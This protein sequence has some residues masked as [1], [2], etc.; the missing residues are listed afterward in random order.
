MRRRRISILILLFV[1]LLSAWGNVI[2]AAFCPRYLAQNCFAHK[3]KR[4]K[5]AEHE[6]CTHGIA[7]TEMGDMRMED[8][9]MDNDSAPKAEVKSVAEAQPTGLVTQSS[10]PRI[11]IERP[12]ETCGHCWMHSQPASGA[13]TLV[14][15]DPSTRLIDTNAPPAECAV[16]LAHDFSVSIAPQEHGPPGNLL[17]RHV[18]INVFRI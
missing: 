4:A 2:G 11:V 6:S 12:E 1:F 10:T 13:A 18:L 5:Q 9:Q 8:M 14:A 15:V 7:V 16:A 3:T 17:P